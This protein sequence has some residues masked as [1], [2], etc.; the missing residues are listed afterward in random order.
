M[1]G[2]LFLGVRR[3]GVHTNHKSGVVDALTELW[4]VPICDGWV[5]VMV[6]VLGWTPHLLLAEDV[7]CASCVS[8]CFQPVEMVGGSRRLE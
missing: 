5:L 3:W 2:L 8:G 4:G 6:L 7:T 1:R